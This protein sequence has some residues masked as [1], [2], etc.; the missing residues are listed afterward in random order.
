MSYTLPAWADLP[1]TTSALNTANLSLY[2]TAVND[3][4]TRINAKQANTVVTSVKTT[5][6]TAAAGE[7]VPVDTTSGNVTVTFPTAPANGTQIGAL[8]VTRGGVNTVTLQLGG[9]DKF[10]T[11]T[12]PT[13]NV[14]TLVGDAASFQYVSSTAVWVALSDDSALSSLDV[15]YKNVPVS[16]AFASPLN[17]NAALG[18]YFRTAAITTAFT[19]ANP[20]NPTDGQVVTW[21]LLQDATGSRVM[22]LDTQFALGGFTATL[23][24]A[25]KRDFLTAVYNSSTTKWYITNFAKNY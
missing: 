5:G 14:L 21:E 18:N 7:F 22:T 17:T 2:N 3:I 15:R 12:G 9:S 20:T 6:Y 13:T 8:Q 10:N 24:G 11:T 25:S 16:L 4:D 19:L 23:S 1:A